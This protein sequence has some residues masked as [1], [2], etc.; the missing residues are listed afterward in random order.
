MDHSQYFDIVKTVDNSEVVPFS[1]GLIIGAFIMLIFMKDRHEKIMN[2][3][4]GAYFL[5]SRALKGDAKKDDRWE[6][7]AIRW[8][9]DF[10]NLITFQSK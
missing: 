10:K 2:L 3:L 4:H 8:L 5:I 6:D 1:F 7:S 9:R